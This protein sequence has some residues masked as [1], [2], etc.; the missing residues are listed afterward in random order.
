MKKILLALLLVGCA[1]PTHTTDAGVDDFVVEAKARIVRDLYYN[2]CVVLC[3][4]HTYY[5]I[6]C[7]AKCSKDFKEIDKVM[8]R[9]IK[10]NK[11]KDFDEMM[12][13]WYGY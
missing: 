13:S 6:D 1:S 2:R 7:P 11:V 3:E 5:G 9:A 8:R 4:K 10:D 12:N